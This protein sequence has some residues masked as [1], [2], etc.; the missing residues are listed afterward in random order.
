LVLLNQQHINSITKYEPRS[1]SVVF[2]Y[3][4]IEEHHMQIAIGS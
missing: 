1:F 4:V 2:K 3:R